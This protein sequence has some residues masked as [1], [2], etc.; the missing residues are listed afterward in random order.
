M[1]RE[2]CELIEKVE[3]RGYNLEK[4]KR[5]VVPLNRN[6]IFEKL[7]LWY[8]RIFIKFSNKYAICVCYH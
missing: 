6:D 8:S 3:N 7:I 2:I 5:I 1:I 4:G